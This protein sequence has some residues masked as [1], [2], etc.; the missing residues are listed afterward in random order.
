MKASDYI[1]KFL[2]E[3]GANVV[4]EMAGGMITHLLDS[5]H[6]HGGFTLVSVH[7]EQ[8]AAFAVDGFSRSS[9]QADCRNGH[10][11]SGSNQSSNWNC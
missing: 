9:K 5:M 6:R 7:H 3:R 10:E 4:F 1:A 11:R 8:A 2:F